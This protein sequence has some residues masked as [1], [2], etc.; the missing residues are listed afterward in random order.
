MSKETYKRLSPKGKRRAVAV[1][2]VE[3]VIYTAMFAALGYICCLAVYGLQ[4]LC[5]VA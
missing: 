4:L 5:G 2:A 3:S 1:I